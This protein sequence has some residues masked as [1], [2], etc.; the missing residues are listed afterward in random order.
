MKVKLSQGG[1]D[2]EVAPSH[3]EKLKTTVTCLAK[4]RKKKAN[5][6]SPHNTHEKSQKIT[7]G[8]NA[9]TPGK[10]LEKEGLRGTTR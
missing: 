8:E 4:K 5:P 6:K 2:Q 1:G 10:N 9:P 7:K 3:G